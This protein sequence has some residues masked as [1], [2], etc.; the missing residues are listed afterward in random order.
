M[1]VVTRPFSDTMS[2]DQPLHIKGRLLLH[3][4]GSTSP[5]IMPL[6]SA[7]SRPCLILFRHPTPFIHQLLVASMALLLP[8]LTVTLGPTT[9][10]LL[11]VRW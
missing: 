1:G 3:Y 9:T 11:Y 5:P 2:T 8:H 6:S 10:S 7:P 4:V